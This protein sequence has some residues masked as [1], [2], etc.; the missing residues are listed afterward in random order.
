MC[1]SVS[2]LLSSFWILKVKKLNQRNITIPFI[3]TNTKPNIMDSDDVNGLQA[4]IPFYLAHNL[5]SEILEHSI[6]ILASTTEHVICSVWH[7]HH[8]VN[9]N[10]FN[11][12]NS[13]LS[14]FKCVYTGHMLMWKCIFTGM[15]VDVED[16][17][18]HWRSSSIIL[19]FIDQC[20]VSHW[21]Y[22]LLTPL[23]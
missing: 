18:W 13:Q 4:P 14:I 3:L 20:R 21:T 16:W 15:H 19:H 7:L 11:Y 10:A 9:T 22:S 5:K 1:I 17:G 8:S 23:I 12:I 2:K 6:R